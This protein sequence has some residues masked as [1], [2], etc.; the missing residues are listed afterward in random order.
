MKVAVNVPPAVAEKATVFVVPEARPLHAEKA[1]PAEGV[2]A[3]ETEEASLTQP[4]F[5]L[6]VPPALG[7]MDTVTY[8]WRR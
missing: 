7:V 8:H 6:I 2:S 4:L 1:Y 3:K 5:G